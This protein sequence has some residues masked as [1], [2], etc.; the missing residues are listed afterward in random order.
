MRHDVF[1]VLLGLDAM[2]SG[3]IGRTDDHID[4]VAIVL[5]GV[6]VL[7]SPQ[8]MTLITANSCL[9]QLLWGILRRDTTLQCWFC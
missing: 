8:P 5:K 3:A 6:L 9:L 7:I 4:L 1:S 2:A